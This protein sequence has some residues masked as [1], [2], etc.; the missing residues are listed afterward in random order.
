MSSQCSKSP[1]GDYRLIESTKPCSIGVAVLFCF[2]PPKLFDPSR[3]H[4]SKS[5]G[6]SHFFRVFFPDELII[7]RSLPNR[8]FA[9]PFRHRLAVDLSSGRVV[10]FLFSS[11]WLRFVSFFFCCLWRTRRSNFIW[12]RRGTM[13]GGQKAARI[14]TSKKR[15]SSSCL[16]SKFI[17]FSARFLFLLYLLDFTGFHGALPDHTLFHWTWN[18]LYWV[19]QGFTE[20]Y[21]VLLGFTGFYRIL[22]G[23]TGFYGFLLG[24]TGI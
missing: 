4:R 19:W 23:F 20:F 11:V 10:F 6:I 2:F 14:K 18:G 3:F 16:K 21:W 8:F 1:A 24:F 9:G 13:A 15:N 5:T 22:L 7:S 17:H 12:R